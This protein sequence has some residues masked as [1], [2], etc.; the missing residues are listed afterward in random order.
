MPAFVRLLQDN[1][2]EVRVAA[3]KVSAL[4]QNLQQRGRHLRASAVHQ[5]AVH[6]LQPVRPTQPSPEPSPLPNTVTLTLFILSRSPRNPLIPRSPCLMSL[7]MG[8]RLV[9]TE[10]NA[11]CAAT[12]LLLSLSSF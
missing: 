2:A 3:T 7:K 1:E 11:R 6:R 4:L 10:H 9:L 8:L 12:C 5:G